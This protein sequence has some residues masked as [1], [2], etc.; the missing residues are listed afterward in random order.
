MA[1]RIDIK[2]SQRAP[3]STSLDA[4]RSPKAQLIGQ[5]LS[6][7][8]FDAAAA[9][10]ATDFQPLSDLRASSAY[11]L[12]AAGNLLRRFALE[13]TQAATPLRTHALDAGSLDAPA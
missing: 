11:R 10:L 5:V 3:E 6:V 9:A 4:E 1:S 13:Q 2:V 12:R 7:A 8:S